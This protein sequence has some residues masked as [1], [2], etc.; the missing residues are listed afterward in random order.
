METRLED[1]WRLLEQL[2]REY[3]ASHN[4]ADFDIDEAKISAFEEYL[5]KPETD[6]AVAFHRALKR[7]KVRRL[8]VRIRR[9]SE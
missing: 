4:R 7:E 8:R 6:L 2:D 9:E 5:D 1:A 3:C